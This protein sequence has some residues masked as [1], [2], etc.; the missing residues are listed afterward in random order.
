MTRDSTR[1]GC[2]RHRTLRLG[3]RCLIIA[4]MRS[5]ARLSVLL[6]GLLLLTLPALAAA[7]PKP[8]KRPSSIA[9]IQPNKAP[10]QPSSPPAPPPAPPASTTPP[11]PPA[12]TTPPAGTDD[13]LDRDEH[14]VTGT[15]APPVKQPV[16][17]VT[18]QGGRI[19][20]ALR[21]RRLR[22]RAHAARAG[23]RRRSRD[24]A[25]HQHPRLEDRTAGVAGCRRGVPGGAHRAQPPGRPLARVVARDLVSRLRHCETP[26]QGEVDAPGFAIP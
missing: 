24:V 17:V 10:V 9:P 22:P 8:I 25:W 3:A 26:P 15:N 12:S 2:C 20:R 16:V 13:G 4:E 5:P 23:R 14:A 19:S 21:C 18:V 11:A 1:T 6:A 7:E